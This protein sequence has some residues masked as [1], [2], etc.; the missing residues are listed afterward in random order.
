MRT[1]QVL[2]ISTC[3]VMKYG[4]AVLGYGI[5]ACEIWQIG[6]LIDSAYAIDARLAR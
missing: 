6:V 5:G 3:E 4:F 2:F 1:A